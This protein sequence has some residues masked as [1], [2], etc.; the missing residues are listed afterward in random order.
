VPAQNIEL[1]KLGYRIRK[2]RKALSYSQKVFAAKCGLDRSYLGGVER[3]ERNVT[4]GVLCAICVGLDCDIAAITKCIPRST[5]CLAKN[6]LPSGPA[7]AKDRLCFRN[8]ALK[9]KKFLL[10][11]SPW[12]T[13]SQRAVL[14]LF[15]G[16]LLQ[17]IAPA[18]Q[19]R[20]TRCIFFLDIER[21]FH[22]PP[23]EDPY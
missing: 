18:R 1:L 5:R 22:T 2:A 21:R 11:M 4:F 7:M 3:G 12:L 8:Q 23:I 6:P 15:D 16:R 9:Q 10:S 14:V 20:K 13:S 17:R 19:L